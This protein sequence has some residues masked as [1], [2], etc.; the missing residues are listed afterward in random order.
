M[1]WSELMTKECIDLTNA[2]R[3]GDFT[4]ADLQIDPRTGRI[5]AIVIPSTRSWFGKK[6]EDQKLRW[7]AIQTIGADLVIIDM[8]RI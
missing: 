6:E 2:E 4:R 5:E 8:R 1:R 7:S 3:V